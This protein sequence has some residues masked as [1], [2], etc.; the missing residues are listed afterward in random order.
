MNRKKI[1]KLKRLKQ[2][3]GEINC[4]KRHNSYKIWALERTIEGL[5]KIEK[6]TAV[7][8][9]E[10]KISRILTKEKAFQRD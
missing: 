2:Q 8:T 1:L 4:M 7:I 9:I 3:L 6:N 5:L 10:H